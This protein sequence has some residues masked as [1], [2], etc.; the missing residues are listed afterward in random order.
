MKKVTREK[1]NEFVSKLNDALASGDKE[2]IDL[3]EQQDFLYFHLQYNNFTTVRCQSRKSPL[4]WGL[5]DII[6]VKKYSY[7]VF[8]DECKKHGRKEAVDRYQEK[9]QIQIELKKICPICGNEF[10]ANRASKKTCSDK[11]R[12][13]ASIKKVN[14]PKGQ[15]KTELR[16]IEE[17]KIKIMR[18]QRYIAMIPSLYSNPKNVEESL[19]TAKETLQSLLK[20]LES[21]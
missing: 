18:Q 7:R 12:K 20:Q 3:L 6:G 15:T 5:I 17:L 1:F 21:T 11:C 8:C 10:I 4:C 14:I 9:K 19:I 2:K 16:K 13:Q